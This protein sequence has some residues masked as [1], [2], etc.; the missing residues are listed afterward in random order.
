MASCFLKISYASHSLLFTSF[1][2]IKLTFS[3]LLKIYLIKY[4]YAHFL[5]FHSKQS[6]SSP[7]FRQLSQ[8][9]KSK[10]LPAV[11]K[12]KLRIWSKKLNFHMAKFKNT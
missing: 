12:Q 4:H 7:N 10:E 6:N 11:E 2:P 9:C 1:S 8:L 5:K 3:V